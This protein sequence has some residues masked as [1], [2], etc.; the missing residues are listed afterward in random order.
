M[1]LAYRARTMQ[2]S[3]LQPA[4]PRTRVLSFHGGARCGALIPPGCG[5]AVPRTPRAARRDSLAGLRAPPCCFPLEAHAGRCCCALPE[6]RSRSLW[7]VRRRRDA[8]LRKFP[9]ARGRLWRVSG[10]G[11]RAGRSALRVPEPRR[12]RGGRAG[13]GGRGVAICC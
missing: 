12:V 9:G 10:G 11:C 4:A 6:V 1:H 7:P 5:S 8:V 2:T 3:R 13:P